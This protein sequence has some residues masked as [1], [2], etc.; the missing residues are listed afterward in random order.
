MKHFDHSEITLKVGKASRG[1]KSFGIYAGVA[2]LAKFKT[3]EE[4]VD[5][6]STNRKFYEYWAG[7]V[8]VITQNTP[9]NVIWV[10]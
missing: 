4:A 7:S 8:S 5:Q 6:L 1:I 2:C 10:A 9:P 3:L